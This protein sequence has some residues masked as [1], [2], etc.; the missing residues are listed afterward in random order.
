MIIWKI[1]IY[2]NITICETQVEMW[3]CIKWLYDF[4]KCDYWLCAKHKF[5]KILVSENLAY[6]KNWLCENAICMWKYEYV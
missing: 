3:L 6:W 2:N 1:W 4:F 5:M